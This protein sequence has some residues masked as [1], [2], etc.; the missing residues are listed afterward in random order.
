MSE[1]QQ[2]LARAERVEVV[3]VLFRN[4]FYLAMTPT[5]NPSLHDLEGE[6]WKME[7]QPGWTIT[8]DNEDSLTANSTEPYEAPA[9]WRWVA[10][11]ALVLIPEP[12]GPPGKC[13][14]HGIWFP[15]AGIDPTPQIEAF[16]GFLC[17]A[18]E[19]ISY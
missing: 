18:M 4:D 10:T 17:T 11:M 2:L 5:A 9:G 1:I 19:K 14:G 7:F 13:F 6:Y 16:I 8:A 3:V 12:T 15:M